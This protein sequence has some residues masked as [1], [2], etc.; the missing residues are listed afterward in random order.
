MEFKDYEKIDNAIEKAQESVVP[1]PVVDGDALTVI[2]DANATEINK[3]DFKMRFRVPAKRDDGTTEYIRRE[4]EYTDVF[5][6]P[7]H[8]SKI[9]EMIAKLMPFF[10]KIREDGGIE[11]M[12]MDEKREVIR[13]MDREIMDLLYDVTT[14]VLGID[15]ELKEYMLPLDVVRAATQIIELYP[16]TVNEADTFFR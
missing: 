2:G 15:E 11:A 3:H 13:Q 8:D 1:F 4:K 6:K 9:V 10:K 16:E 7:R 12:T 14:M 5:I